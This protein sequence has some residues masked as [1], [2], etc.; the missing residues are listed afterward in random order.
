MA[1]NNN[2]I[3][4]MNYAQKQINQLTPEIYAAIALALHRVYGFSSKRIEKV[5]AESQAIWENFVNDRGTMI[6]LCED[7]T[8]IR[9]N[10]L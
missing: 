7:E 4:A 3:A 8:G 10:N 1:K 6:D 2:L 9:V 5:F